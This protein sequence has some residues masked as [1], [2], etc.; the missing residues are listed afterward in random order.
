MKLILAGVCKDVDK[1]IPIIK[2][3]YYELSKKVEKIKG[4]FYENNS[5]DNTYPL[6][7]D[8]KNEDKNIEVFSEN[9]DIKEL[10][11]D[12]KA[13]TWDNKPCRMEII[14]LAR[15]NLMKMIENKKYKDFDYEIMIDMDNKHILPVDSIINCI[16]KY[17]GSFD[18]LIS[19]GSNI[20]GHMYDTYAFRN[21]LFPYG[22]EILGQKWWQPGYQRIIKDSVLNLTENKKILSG[23]NGLAIFKKSSINGVRY[24]GVPT[25]YSNMVY[26]KYKKIY[27]DLDYKYKIEIPPKNT[28]YEG[29]LLGINLFGDNDFFYLNNSGYN[30]PIICEHIPFF[31]EMICKGNDNI[32][33]CP[34]LLWNWDRI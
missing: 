2:Q 32:Y 25:K 28:H 14:A 10:L 7:R 23:F 31:S 9:I 21:E 26:N 34:E 6:L 15:N 4:V 30:Y 20:R 5:T 3:G 16:N 33:L 17:H 18:T 19:Y 1:F 12:C 13:T 29:C 22:P 8:W 27:E 24:S 11:K